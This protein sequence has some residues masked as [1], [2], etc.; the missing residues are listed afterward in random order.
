MTEDGKRN[1]QGIEILDVVA[2]GDE[3]SDCHLINPRDGTPLGAVVRIKGAFAPQFAE[4]LSKIRRRSA[5]RERNAIARAVSTED[6]V[7]E[8]SE[9]LAEMTITW[10]D[11]VE[12]GELVP[13]SKAA[14]KRI[15]VK[16]PLI[17]GQ[18][19]NHALDVSNFTTG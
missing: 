14:A 8:T 16:Y 1:V 18:V 15:Y 3:G 19:F 17:R 9:L 11:V 10:T 6:D 2:R 7:E 12:N 13:F 5:I 4:R